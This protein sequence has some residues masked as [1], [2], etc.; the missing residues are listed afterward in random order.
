MTK[1]I[2]LGVA[3]G[4]GSGKTTIAKN[5][6]EMV[7]EHRV[8]HLQHDAYYRHR[9]EMAA[10][11][12]RSVNYD[13]PDSLETELLIEHIEALIS[14]QTVNIPIYDFAVH[15][16]K[17]EF[18]PL[19]SRSIVLI[20]GI[21]IFSDRELREL[22]DVKIFVDTDAD[23]RFIRRLKRDIE[24]RGR[25]MNSVME[26]YLDTVRPMHLQFVEPSKRYADVIIP[27]GGRNDV[28]MNMLASLLRSMIDIE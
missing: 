19:E 20:E 2:V 6:V 17:D 25:S 24:L 13:H 23:V 10:E 26:Q 21:L 14:G 11:K 22:M 9:P 7:G 27:E 28:A 4:T 5:I 18:R 3:G 15:L 16:R 8:A 1:P 12:R